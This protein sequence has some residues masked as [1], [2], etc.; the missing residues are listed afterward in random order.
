M[1]G[2][3]L[4]KNDGLLPIDLGNNRSLA[5]IGDWANATT[6]MQGNYRG[7]SPYLHSP[8]YAAE[9]LTT[10]YYAKGIS[11]QGD[12]TTGLWLPVWKAAEQ[13]DVIVYVGGIDNDVE[14]EGHD[15]VS[16]A[17][18]GAQMDVIGQLASYGKPTIVVQMGGGQLDSSPIL[19]NPNI[20][21]ILWGGYPGQ[22]G[23]VALFDIITGKAA[24]AGR[25]PITQY[26][27]D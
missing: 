2:I 19:S 23:G 9:Q 24:P 15:R 4:L 16:L 3:V 18:S 7:P 12:P 14:S 27:A 5:L 20:S 21:A 10:V 11:G 8:L 1:E 13:A 17:W 22:D 25:L 6:Q 26:P